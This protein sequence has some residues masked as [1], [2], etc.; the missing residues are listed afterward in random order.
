MTTFY[1]SASLTEDQNIARFEITPTL[2]IVQT[3]QYN[4]IDEAKEAPL[5]QQMFYLPFVK[6]VVLKKEAVEIMRFDILKWEEVLDDVSLEIE[7]FLNSGS[8][9]IN[10]TP[11]SKKNPITVYAESTPNPSVMKFVTNKKLVDQIYEFKNIDETSNAPLAQKLFHF[12]FVKEVF[13]DTNY[14]SITKFDVSKWDEIVMEIREFL[15][16]FLEEGNEITTAVK[17]IL[18]TKTAEKLEV[19]LDET[20]QQIIGIIEDYIKPAVAADGG[21]IL[22]DS[23]NAENKNVQVV[24]QGA[25]SGCPS[26]TFT[27]KNGIENMLKEMLPGKISS[28]NAI[29][30]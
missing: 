26:S 10:E 12:P 16:S 30:G 15:R 9:A 7:N 22:F 8:V 3:Y 17:E 28:V 11:A 23:Y 14:I 21:N 6:S 13:M 29:N 27:L 2:Q 18:N 4:N 1:V 19:E 25:C 5:A 24:L 20:S